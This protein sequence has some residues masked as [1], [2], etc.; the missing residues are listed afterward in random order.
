MRRITIATL[1][2]ALVALGAC[3]Q[4]EQASED[5]PP[6]PAPAP[7]PAPKTPELFEGDHEDLEPGETAVWKSGYRVTILSPI[8]TQVLDRSPTMNE[9]DAGKPALA[10]DLTVDN[11]QG[12]VPIEM[13]FRHCE[14]QNVNG[15]MLKHVITP[16][17]VNQP[18]RIGQAPLEPGQ[19]RSERIALLLVGDTS[20]VTVICSPG[21]SSG[22][23]SHES[24]PPSN[25]S[26]S[27][28]ITPESGGSTI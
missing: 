19:K 2:L 18:Q 14:G 8:Q 17:N 26:S 22:A 7:P 13:K 25:I 21:Y 15:E 6:A 4:Q 3:G 24:V 16:E 11:S 23:T 27:W 12:T 1:L 28:K 10:L 20:E 5:A 9:P